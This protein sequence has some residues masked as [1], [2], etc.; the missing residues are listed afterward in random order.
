MSAVTVLQ[1][2]DRVSAMLEERMG[3]RGSSL[4]DKLRKA[5]RRLPRK[6]RDALSLLSEAEEM[7]QNPKLLVR[8]DETRV[9]E[10]Y[11]LCLRHL[12]KINRG[13]RLKSTVLNIA[14]SAAFAILVLAVLVIGFLYWRGLL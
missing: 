5:G 14:A 6:V 3:L 1:M 10:A 7:A 12:G 13:K 9:A 8:V 2:T 11:D 4:S